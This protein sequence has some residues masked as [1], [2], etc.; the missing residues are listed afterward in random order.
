MKIHLSEWLPCK[1]VGVL[2]LNRK[3]V[4]CFTEYEFRVEA[5]L[6]DIKNN[7]EIFK[8][9][10]ISSGEVFDDLR[11]G[12]ENGLIYAIS[13]SRIIMYHG[14]NLIGVSAKYLPVIFKGY[15]YSTENFER[16]DAWKVIYDF[17]ELGLMLWVDNGIVESADCLSCD[18]D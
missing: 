13:C 18:D 14:F 8:L 10:R 17:D 7:I 9:Y 2:E 12:V 1:K 4:T 15:Q 11:V 16:I 3:L 6:S 5:E